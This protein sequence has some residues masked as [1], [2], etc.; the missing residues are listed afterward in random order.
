MK[1][2]SVF[3]WSTAMFSIASYAAPSNDLTL[4]EK[5]LTPIFV[6]EA[7]AKITTEQGE[8]KEWRYPYF[9]GNTSSRLKQFNSWL[10][11]TSIHGLFPQDDVLAEKVL[12]SKDSQ[13]IA[14]LKTDKA[15]QD[16]AAEVATVSLDKRFGT[17]FFLTTQST[18]RG[19]GYFINVDSVV[20]DYAAGKEINI[21]NLF[22]GE[23]EQKLSDLLADSIRKTLEKAKRE[24]RACL[25]KNKK[26][27]GYSCP[28]LNIDADQCINSALFH[29]GWLYIKDSR[30]LQY[31]VPYRPN[32]AADCGYEDS[33]EIH[34]PNVEALFL[35]PARFKKA[36][37]FTVL[38]N[39]ESQAKE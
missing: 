26:N 29:W 16:I 13:V 17:L 38:P 14:M 15:V 32:V 20:Y 27:P 36:V 12:K 6:K 39:V 25:M 7:G 9:V 18:Y 1:I 31:Y 19:V 4:A 34:G 21:A 33:F 10:R 28:E 2:L 5:E 11:E 8:E 30:H 24:S 22:V 23:A 37:R 35:E 3:V